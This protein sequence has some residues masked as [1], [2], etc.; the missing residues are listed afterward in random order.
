MTSITDNTTETTVTLITQKIG[1]VIV[2][3]HRLT[4]DRDLVRR[5]GTATNTGYETDSVKKDRE[6]QETN[7]LG[8][9][10]SLPSSS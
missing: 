1:T 3:N 9:R 5:T 2:L 4:I 10:I 6:S 7:M 8:L